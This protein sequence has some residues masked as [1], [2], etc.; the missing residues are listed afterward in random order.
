MLVYVLNKNNE[1][2]MPCKPAKAKK[3]L[4]N[5]KAKVIRRE[6]FTIQLLFASSGYTQDINLGV[7]AGSRFVGLSATTERK[8]LFAS[9]VELRNDIMDKIANRKQN[10]RR[11][12]RCICNIS[13]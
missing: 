6:P 12:S 1:P 8:E 5:K 11:R 10:R 9:V 7:D 4:K 2:L 3:L 13:R